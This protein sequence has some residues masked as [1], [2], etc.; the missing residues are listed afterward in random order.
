MRGLVDCWT[1]WTT[2]FMLYYLVCVPPGRG[3]YLCV[4]APCFAYPM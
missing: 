1:I 4:F 3:D 2:T